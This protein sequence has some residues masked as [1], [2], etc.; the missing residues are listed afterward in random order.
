MTGALFYATNVGLGV[1]YGVYNVTN[2]TSKIFT[3]FYCLVGSSFIAA[4]GGMAVQSILEQ[5]ASLFAKDL[6]LLHVPK[7]WGAWYRKYKSRVQA[8]ATFIVWS[9][10][11]IIFSMTGNLQCPPTTASDAP[12]NSCSDFAEALFFVI[13]S[14]STASQVPP[15]QTPF[16][17][18]FTI[19]YI[20]IGIPLYGVVWG[21]VA[22]VFISRYYI[23]GFFVPICCV[24]ITF[25]SLL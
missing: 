1:G 20:Y 13:T 21:M 11:G 14:M 3:V 18:L 6:N 17:L 23:F 2:P 10:I 7:T 25:L 4:T 16:P 12:G 19:F 24:A 8:M 5:Q 15:K 9:V 22:D